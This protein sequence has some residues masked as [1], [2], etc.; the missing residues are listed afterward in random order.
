MDIWHGRRDF[1]REK[2]APETRREI[3]K[4][5]AA[6]PNQCSL[7][8]VF[9]FIGPLKPANEEAAKHD[10]FM[11]IHSKPM[12]AFT[13]A[14]LA[15]EAWL[16]QHA[17]DEAAMVIH[18]DTDNAGGLRNSQDYIRSQEFAN[19]VA[20][21][22]PSNFLSLRRIKNELLFTSKRGTRLLQI[23]DLC[24][25]VMRR[26]LSGKSDP[27][28]LFELLAPQIVPSWGKSSELF[29]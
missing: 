10:Q 14:L 2:Y 28:G 5:L 1:D 25:F 9:G 22:A 11:K 7:L 6:I 20:A 18:E 17:S 4:R 21:V 29:G 8:I 23:A 12:I 3:L 19:N 15:A 13:N 24:A 16:R 26:R 27:D